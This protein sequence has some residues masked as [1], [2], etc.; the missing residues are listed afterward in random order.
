MT[1]QW[2]LLL[3]LSIAF[4]I[5]NQLNQAL[6]MQVFFVNRVLFIMKEFIKPRKC[7]QISVSLLTLFHY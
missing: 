1:V 5:F 4:S 2:K 3:Q 6:V 7:K